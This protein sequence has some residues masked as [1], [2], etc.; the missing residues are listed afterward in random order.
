MRSKSR[1][2]SRRDAA[3]STRADPRVG[4]GLHDGGHR[5]AVEVGVR[6]DEH[7]HVVDGE[8]DERD[9]APEEQGRRACAVLAEKHV[10]AEGTPQEIQNDPRVIEA[11]LGGA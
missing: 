10:I 11:Y 6:V 8:A 9:E 7:E 5:V 4:E 1:A 2:L 3:P